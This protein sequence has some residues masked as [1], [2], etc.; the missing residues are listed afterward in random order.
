MPI[1]HIYLKN[2]YGSSCCKLH[3]VVT[4]GLHFLKKKK[5][6]TREWCTKK[7]QWKLSHNVIC[8]LAKCLNHQLFPNV[9]MFILVYCLQV[10]QLERLEYSS[11]HGRL[12]LVFRV[13]LLHLSCSLWTPAS[14]TQDTILSCACSMCSNRST[15]SKKVSTP[16]LHFQILRIS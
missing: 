1:Y 16:V 10:K 12:Q 4:K 8:I 7:V 6:S 13:S 5:N 14:Q 9:L 3:N 11:V 2:N 15:T